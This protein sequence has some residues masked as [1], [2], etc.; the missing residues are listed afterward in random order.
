MT[1]LMSSRQYLED[2]GMN[3]AADA[4]IGGDVGNLES[5]E[6][7]EMDTECAKRVFVCTNR[8]LNVFVFFTYRCLSNRNLSLS[9]SLV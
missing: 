1:P 2:G 5:L 8:Y 3:V 4:A 6:L 9:A 7:S